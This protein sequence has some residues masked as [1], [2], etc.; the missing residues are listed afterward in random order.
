MHN[1]L[2]TGPEVN[3]GLGFE[4]WP[5]KPGIASQSTSSKESENKPNSSSSNR[6][7]MINTGPK[8][9]Q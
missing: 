4:S 1:S 6:V 3:T 8:F 5:F 2:P 7:A 9:K